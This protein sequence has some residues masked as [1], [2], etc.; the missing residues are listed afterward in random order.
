MRKAFGAF[1]KNMSTLAQGYRLAARSSPR[2]FFIAAASSLIT[3]AQPLIVLFFSSAVINELAGSRDVQMIIRYASLA[4]GIHFLLLWGNAALQRIMKRDGWEISLLRLLATEAEQF[5]RMEFGHTEDSRVS[6]SLAS[7]DVNSRGTGLGLLNLFTKTPR[8][9]ESF[10]S[11]AIASILLRGLFRAGNHTPGN[12]AESPM[13]MLLVFIPL[14]LMIVLSFL[15]RAKEKKTLERMFAHNALLNNTAQYYNGY[16]H[17]DMAAKDIRFYNQKNALMHIFT[18]SASIGSWMR[19][20]RFEGRVSGVQAAML[21]LIGGGVYLVIGLRALSGLYLPGDIARYVG[22]VTAFAAALG[23]LASSAG[24]LYINV[25]YLKPLLEYMAIPGADQDGL[26][27]P[28]EENGAYVFEF[29][30]V[31][32]RYPGADVNALTDVHLQLNSGQRLALVGRNGSG[33]TTLIKLL[34]RL[35]EPTEGEIRLNGVNIKAYNLTQYQRIFSVVF[36]DFTLF[37]LKLSENIAASAAPDTKR[38]ASDAVRAGFGGRL[39]A[40]PHGLDTYL[41]KAFEKT[42]E[43]LSGGE[44]QKIALARALYKDAPVMI[45]D[46]PTAALDP[47]AEHE[48]Y[49]S[50]DHT[51][52]HKTAVFISHRLSSCRFCHR[53]AVFDEGKVAQYGTH[54]SLLDEDGG[55]YRALWYAQA[56]HYT[57]GEGN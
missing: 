10:C 40:M 30:H 51:I 55:L 44:L 57:D 18:Q 11:L 43:T 15:F 38:A 19:F 47:I 8:F 14:V 24:E 2:Y 28:S 3:A 45:L 37:P 26:K 48:I 27:M 35:Y 17:A 52:G 33:K 5:M 50:F 41:G 46:E 16:I 23:S 53:I 25:P 32:F 39:E 7:I 36:Q 6:E 29:I 9:L 54:A 22:A 21:A 1:C 12:F 42:G 49:T 31:S 34:C 4:V 56:E 13:A 20:F